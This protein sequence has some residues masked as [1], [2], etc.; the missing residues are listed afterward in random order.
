MIFL[1]KFEKMKALM[2]SVTAMQEILDWKNS[3]DF[4]QHRLETLLPLIATHLGT[5]SLLLNGPTGLCIEIV[6]RDNKISYPESINLQK[7]N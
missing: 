5:S 6:L 2:V 7:V 4:N 3:L 1:W